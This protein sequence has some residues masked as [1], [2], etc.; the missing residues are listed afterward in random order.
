ME[1]PFKHKNIQVNL[2]NN[3]FW[4]GNQYFEPDDFKAYFRFK[5][6]HS[7]PSMAMNQ[8]SVHPEVLRRSS[9]SLLHQNINL[10]HLLRAYNPD[11]IAKDRIVGSVVAVALTPDGWPEG[12]WDEDEVYPLSEKIT[13][14]PESK[15]KAL[16]LHCVGVIYK[17]A[18]GVN[19][20]L[21]EHLAGRKPW[22]VSIEAVYDY[23]QSGWAIEDGLM[24]ELGLSGSS[25]TPKEF[26]KRGYSYFPTADAPEAISKHWN[27]SQSQ[28]RASGKLVGKDFCLLCGGLE[29]MHQFMGVG[30]TTTPMELEAQITQ[31]V[32]SDKPELAAL[33]HVTRATALAREAAGV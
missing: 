20:V 18:D 27:R 13:E 7:W 11:E 28:S 16:A 4:F 17:Q 15:E 10:N 33:R 29:G 19:R 22:S 25:H 1:I 9:S 6:C 2:Q 12:Y 5:L 26:A 30:L 3:A 32:A 24:R 8:T 14:L 21:G 31:M 23:S